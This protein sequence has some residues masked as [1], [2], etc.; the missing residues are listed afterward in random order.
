MLTKRKIRI[1][2]LVSHPIQYF[3]P[4]YRALSKNPEIDLTVFYY[5]A[6]SL[7][8]YFDPGFGRKVTWDIPLTEGY[9]Y[10]LDNGAEHRNVND[11]FSWRPSW[12]T[13]KD[14]LAKKYD[15]VWLHGYMFVNSWLCTIIGQLR[16]LPILLRDEQTLLTPRSPLK[17]LVKRLILPRIFKHVRGLYVSKSNRDFFE[18]Y[19]TKRLFPVSY[20]VDNAS[21][22]G[23]YDQLKPKRDELR[24]RFGI[25]NQHPT[26][27]FC[28]KLIDKK[29]PQL[30]LEAFRRIRRNKE[31]NLLFAGDGA[32]RGE[33]ET[34]VR[35]HSVPDVYFAG[36]LNQTELP[37]AYTSA[38]IFVLPSYEETWGLV[39]NEAMN[40]HLPIVV[41]DRVGCAADLVQPNVNGNIF[42]SGNVESLEDA[43]RVMVDSPDLRYLYGEKSA[44]IVTHYDI[45]TIAAQISEA[46][47]QSAG[48][49]SKAVEVQ[50]EVR[51][52]TP[53]ADS[54]WPPASLSSPTSQPRSVKTSTLTILYLG[55]DDGT[56]RHRI[57]ALERLG[58]RIHL[59]NPYRFIPQNKLIQKWAFKSGGMFLEALVHGRVLE[60]LPGGRFDVVLV[61]SGEYVGPALVRDLKAVGGAVINYNT[62]DPFGSRD[63]YRWRLYLKSVPLY[64]LV[65][66]VR[67]PNIAEARAR[68][69]RKVLPVYMSADEVAHS[70]RVLSLADH[71]KWDSDV[72][73]IGTWMPERGP[74][75]AKLIQLGVPLSLYGNRWER[76]AEW[77]TIRKVWRGPTVHNEDDYAKAIQCAKICLGLVS[78]GN[79][80]LSTQRSFEVPHLGGL[81]CAQRT[82]EHCDL[83]KEDE[84]AVF[85]DTPEE[86]AQK[87]LLLL[88]DPDLRKKIAERGRLRCLQNGT[89][90]ERVMGAV[91]NAAVE[92]SLSVSKEEVAGKEQLR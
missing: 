90:N 35:S 38:D 53:L 36:F 88:N 42:E 13:L 67:K 49:E 80:D 85:W 39:V 62:D 81:L 78:V 16:D 43:L 1:A 47:L 54:C 23:Q 41:S 65:V 82:E 91:L 15:V 32:L 6:A 9:K 10:I 17:R 34:M 25:A 66:V 83:Y 22:A 3:V 44:E 51:H 26:I 84:E 55:S 59:V 29:Q 20:G 48:S 64:D 68:G 77:N 75:M 86:C 7:K 63:G 2:H 73:F 56:S 92:G 69:A 30:L 28:G 72:T 40:F 76:A 4:L 33:L 12:S 74:F 18:S 11:G 24:Q 31:C 37:A 5:S 50:E 89:T 14:I 71:Q 46:C 57:H 60:C 19:G 79:R 87:C 70:R 27:L 45:D 52:S 58:H 21:L 8:E 61:N